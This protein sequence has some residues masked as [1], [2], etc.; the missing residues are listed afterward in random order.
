MEDPRPDDLVQTQ[1]WGIETEDQ[2]LALA[3]AAWIFLAALD[4]GF[5][6]HH[7]Q[8]G[9][10]AMSAALLQ[11][12]S[13]ARLLDDPLLWTGLPFGEDRVMA[14][15]AAAVELR[16]EDFSDFGEPFA[17]Q[18]SG[19][20]YA[21]QDLVARGH[22]V[23]H[24]VRNDGHYSEADIRQFFGARREIGSGPKGGGQW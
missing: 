8:G 24:S 17:V 9:A 1:A 13:D 14:L 12:L 18:A 20:P 7:C 3:R 22:S 19:L 6:G 4:S 16:V 23:T 5:D 21:P 10:Y 15:C 11:R 2:R